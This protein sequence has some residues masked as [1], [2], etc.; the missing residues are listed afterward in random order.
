MKIGKVT[1]LSGVLKILPKILIFDHLIL[2][3]ANFS[4]LLAVF[5]F[6]VKI[7]SF[8]HLQPETIQVADFKICLPL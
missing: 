5:N 8:D 6:L 4:G 7:I 2:D 1:L 3:G